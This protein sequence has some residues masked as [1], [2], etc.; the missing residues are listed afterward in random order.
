MNDDGVMDAVV[1]GLAKL[2]EC[3]ACC[4]AALFWPRVRARPQDRILSQRPTEER[5]PETSDSSPAYTITECR[6]SWWRRPRVSG[7]SW[8]LDKKIR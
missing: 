4:R 3:E 2:V 1:A 6:A 5:K 8:A 7:S